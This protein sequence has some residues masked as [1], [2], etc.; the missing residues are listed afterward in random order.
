MVAVAVLASRAMRVIAWLFVLTAATAFPQTA[1]AQDTAPYREIRA[2][3]PDGRTVAVKGLTL[4]RDAYQLELRSGAVHLLAPV[5]GNTFGAVF[6]GDGSYVL[7]PASAAERR[8]L[9]LVSGNERLEVLTDR[10]SQLILLFTDRTAEEVL[11]HAPVVSGAPDQAAVRVVEDYVQKQLAGAHPNLHLRVVADLLNRPTRNDGVFLAMVQGQS[12]APVLLAVD[13]LGLSS[14]TTRFAYFG[15]EEV[16]LVSFDPQNGGVWYLSGSIGQA[17]RTRPIRTLADASH[18]EIETALDGGALRGKTTV[19]FTPTVEGVRVLPIHLFERLRIRTAVVE[20]GGGAVPVG[21]LQEDPAQGWL[22]RMFGDEVAAADVALLFRDPLPRGTPVRVAIEYEG[23]DVLQ[24]S[25]GRFVVQARESWYPN[26]GTFTDL[27][28]YDMTF[29]YSD[30]Q[31]LVGVGELVEERTEGGRKVARWRSQVPIRVAGFNYGEFQKRSQQDKES[32]L[33]IDVYAIRDTNDFGAM[34]PNAIAD[35]INASR[36]AQA[37][38]G[39]PPYR[40]LSVTQ[41]PQLNAGQSWPS[42]VFLPTMSF[43]SATDV[44]L[45]TNIDPRALAGL[46]EFGNTVGWHEVAHQWWGHQ[47]GWASYRDTWLSEGMAEFTAGLTLEI[48]MGR[49]AANQFWALRRRE[50]LDRGRGV[51]H[52]D[53]GPIS[54][55]P[56]LSTSRS[57]G[58]ARAI[59]YSKGA[60]AVHMLRMMMREDRVPDP[61]RAFKAMMQEFVTTWA[62]RNP[63]TDDFQAIVQRH[64]TKTMN[65]TGDGRIDYFFN[66]WIHGTDIPTVTS[67][68]QVTELGAGKYRVAGT[69]TQADV[70]AGFRTLVPIYLDFGDNRLE[71]LGTVA[72]SGPVAQKVS[73]D[74]GLPARPRRVLINGMHD[75]LTR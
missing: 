46:K 17:T 51:P 34:A 21:V 6:I 3:R 48:A 22:G 71:R 2:A 42:L 58:A 4:V 27:A 66:Q 59:I 11:A 60:Y 68:L 62:G 31:Q 41:Q 26:L 12:W 18:Y 14:L 25:Q 28:T 19:T 47:I 24:G 23:R 73:A 54:Q 63:S 67:D 56:R 69:I 5:G 10:F 52:N 29:R 50:V 7:N 44:A 40:R 64:M 20:A 1:L 55:G 70:P 30:R 57:P 49:P 32:G 39:A 38:F 45:A 43:L 16:S 74:I 33:G 72:L 61:D 37:Y 75:V 36:V 65:L 8:H 9:A 35:A 15:G 53:A 13:P